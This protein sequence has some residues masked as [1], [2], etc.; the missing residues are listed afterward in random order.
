[1]AKA[2]EQKTGSGNVLRKT[3]DSPF[4]PLE[5]VKTNSGPLCF[6]SMR[7]EEWEKRGKTQAGAAGDQKRYSFGHLV[8]CL[9]VA[10]LT[11]KLESTLLDR[12]YV[13]WDQPEPRLSAKF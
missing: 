9:G 7:M 8:T 3:I 1:M 12:A 10:I 6:L 4:P 13:C 5:E 11:Y 2:Q